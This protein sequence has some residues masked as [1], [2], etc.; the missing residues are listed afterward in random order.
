MI[1]KTIAHYEIQEKIGTGGMGV[2]YRAQDTRLGR[3]VALKFL[4]REACKDKLALERFLLEARAAS[5]LNHPSIC[6]I[7]DIGEHDDQ[8]FF[9]MELLEGQ[10]LQQML[11]GSPIQTERLLD[12][13]LQIV[14][15]LDVAHSKEILHR[16]IKPA[17]IFV[18]DRNQAKILDFGLAKLAYPEANVIESSAPTTDGMQGTSIT[19]PGIVVGTVAYMSPEQAR[20]EDVDARTDIFSFGAVLYEM[21]TGTQAFSGKTAAAIFDAILNRQPTQPRQLNPKIPADLERIIHKAMERDREL[22]YQSVAELRADLKRLA[23]G[24]SASEER[25]PPSI[26]VLP[27]VNMS[28][29]PE[30]E[31]F[32]DGMAEEIINAL[33]KIEA[34][35]VSSRTSSFA[36]KGKDEDIRR[37]GRS[38]N[39]ATVLEGSVRKAGNRLRITVQLVNVDDGYRLWSERFDRE[40]EDVFAV[41]D[42]I[43]E[44]IANALRVVLSDREKK[45]IRKIPT[46]NMDAYDLY[47]RGLAYVRQ[48]RDQTLVFA[49]DMFRKAVEID[50]DFALAWAGIAEACAWRHSWFEPTEELRQRAEGA[51]RRALEIDPDLAEAHVAR[52]LAASLGNDYAG[53]REAFERA[54]HLDPKLYDA[55]YYH[56]RVCLSE[57]RMEEAAK[58]FAK[59]SEVRPEEYQAKSLLLNCL[60]SL[61]RG[62]EIP[63]AA[64]RSLDAIE[65]HLELQP[66][67]VRAVY[68][69][70]CS[71]SALGDSEKA[72]EWARRA[73][74]MAPNETGVRYNVACTYLHEGMPEEALDLLEKNVDSGWGN[75]TWV[76]NDPD[77]E[78]VREHPRFRAIL[79]KMPGPGSQA[80]S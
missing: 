23:R 77:W 28:P 15:A 7:Y 22:R 37:I 30:N 42:E 80:N 24:T 39:V 78:S 38:L 26:A 9:A 17:N 57:G 11:A 56:G 73:L 4:P 6:T 16:D 52:G 55:Y 27:F 19:S 67:D 34:L 47:L 72:L 62:E 64:R 43:A 70:S 53:A 63:G 71:W 76:E 45:A 59:A 61:D 14:D 40:L 66:D 60:Q 32:T 69:A 1:G 2:V 46:E 50:P 12:L 79:D 54:I 58:H 33:S 5:A 21:S 8:P 68:F 74:D 10:T 36:F 48:I 3:L 75:R 51:S 31:Y 44:S 65:K 29:D 41:Q 25:E 13:A 18:T 35:R 49:Y 20:G